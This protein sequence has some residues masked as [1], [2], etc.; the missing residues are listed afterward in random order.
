MVDGVKVA[1][2]GFVKLAMMESV[3]L[4]ADS[5]PPVLLKRAPVVVTYPVPRLNTPPERLVK[6]ELAPVVEAEP[7][8]TKIEPPL[9]TVFA[10]VSSPVLVEMA[11]PPALFVT[12]PVTRI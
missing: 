6:G 10:K 11:P 7:A 2:A 5:M 4:P 9:E 12:A 1:P 8:L 3:A